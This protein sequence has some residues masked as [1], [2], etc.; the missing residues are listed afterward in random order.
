MHY[1]EGDK[2]AALNLIEPT[3]KKEESGGNSFHL[4]ITKAKMKMEEGS[5]EEALSFYYQAEKNMNLS[6]VNYDMYND[7]AVSLESLRRY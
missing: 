6:D 3:L 7:M 5:Y 1:S 2:E 4:L